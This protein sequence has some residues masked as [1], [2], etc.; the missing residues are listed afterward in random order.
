[1][2]ARQAEFE[3][4]KTKQNDTDFAITNIIQNTAV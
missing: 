1:M 2:I 3:N 4:L